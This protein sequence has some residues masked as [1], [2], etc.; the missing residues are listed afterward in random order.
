MERGGLLKKGGLL[1]NVEL[2]NRDN[3]TEEQKRKARNFSLENH[4]KPAID[5]L[6]SISQESE[7][8]KKAIAMGRLAKEK[9]VATTSK[10]VSTSESQAKTKEKPK[11][12]SSESS[13]AKKN[14]KGSKKEQDSKEGGE[15]SERASSAKVAPVAASRKLTVEPRKTPVVSSKAASSITKALGNMDNFT[16]ECTTSDSPTR[17]SIKFK[18][19]TGGGN[20]S[21]GWEVTPSSSGNDKL[22]PELVSKIQ[23]AL[24]SGL[25]QNDLQHA[26]RRAVA[27]EHGKGKAVALKDGEASAQSKGEAGGGSRPPRVSEAFQRTKDKLGGSRDKPAA[28]TDQ[29]SQYSRLEAD[30]K[31]KSPQRSNNT[32]LKAEPLP[33]TQLAPYPPQKHVKHPASINS[34]RQPPPRDK[35]STSYKSSSDEI[36]S[37]RQ[38]LYRSES[39]FERPGP[40]GEGAPVISYKIALRC[41]ARA[42]S[43]VQMLEFW[44]MPETGANIKVRREGGRGKIPYCNYTSAGKSFITLSSP[45]Q[46]QVLQS[47]KKL[48]HTLMCNS[49]YRIYSIRRRTPAALQ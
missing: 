12:D 25:V 46:P 47:G 41:L 21:D 42:S 17:Q 5:K 13:E 24:N 2:L 14:G 26:V 8:R 31:P 34:V 1:E 20:K 45:I 48:Y 38:V 49:V 19:S 36:C 40:D 16:L 22:P 39:K 15:K 11:R 6:S 32:A 10:K 30:N 27:E 23:E 35:M 4:L 33:E 18:K 29:G 37:F 7:A 3:L 9:E 43:D 44:R 28:K